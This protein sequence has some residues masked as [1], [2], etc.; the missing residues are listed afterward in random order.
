[1]GRR[2]TPV[3]PATGPVQRFAYELRKL[4]QEAGGLTYREMARRAHYSVTSL[5]QAAAGEQL[6]S[7][8][9]TLAYV[10][11]CGGDPEEWDRRWHEASEESATTREDDDTDA[12]YPGLSRYEPT[13]HDRFFGRDDLVE[14][15]RALTA[16]HRFTAVFGPSGSGKSSLLRAGLIPDLQK[17][18]IAALRI[19]TPG[20]HPLRT[21][22]KALEPQNDGGPGDRGDTGDTVLVVDQ[23][24]EV[25]TLC[26]DQT[27]RTEFIDRLLAART[28][29]GSGLRVVVAVRAD[30]YGHCAEHRALAD[31]LSEASLLVGPMTRAELREA[32]IRPAQSAG[33]IVER[34]LTAHLVEEVDGEPGGLPLL[35]HAL[36]ET[37]RR[38]RGRALTMAAYEAAGGVRG[39]IAKTA[40]DVYA[41]LSPEQAALARQL[42]LRLITPG[43]GS[44]DTRR[45]V[46]RTELGFAPADEVALVLERLTRARLLTLDDNTV[47]LAHE[48]LI[49]S[50]PR[51]H[52]WIGETREHLRTHRRLTEAA[53]AWDDLGR[54]P[55]AL[56]RGTRLATADE[57]LTDQPLAPLEEAFL[58]AS[59]TTHTTELRRRR[60]LFTTLATLLV[61]ALIAGVTAWQQSRTSDRRHREAEARRIATVADSMRFADPVKAM[62]LSVAAWR[63]A[64]T[65]ETRSALLGGMTQHELDT[66]AVPDAD[67]GRRSHQDTPQTALDVTA[68]GRTLVSVSR[69]R[70]RTWD[71]RT[72][73]RTHDHPGP[74]KLMADGSEVVIS[75]DGRLLAL[76]NQGGTRL[77]DVHTG[78]E[79]GRLGSRN[80]SIAAFGPGGRTL[81]VQ[82]D[83][84]EA[85]VAQVWDVRTLRRLIQVGNDF[86]EALRDP[87]TD[88]DG[89]WLVTC[90]D[91]W[92]LQVWDIA[93]QRRVTPPWASR[94][95][96]GSCD[97]EG[98]YGFS[99]DGRQFLVVTDTGVQRW[100]LRSNR[101]LPTVE[102]PGASL[103][104][105]RLSADGR[106]MVAHAGNEIQLWRL[107]VS[108]LSGPV[109]HHALVSEQPGDVELDLAAGAVRYLTPG[110]T[111]VRSLS[112]GRA[113]SRWH[114]QPYDGVLLA[115]DGRTLAVLSPN[116]KTAF[117]LRDTRSGRVISRPP[118]NPCILAGTEAEPVTDCSPPMAF[119]ADGRYFAY[120]QTGANTEPGLSTRQ[121]VMVWD[122]R[123][124]REHAAVDIRTTDIDGVGSLSLTPDG[125]TLLVA[126]H[127]PLIAKSGPGSP[128]VE[129]WDLRRDKKSKGAERARRTRSLPLPGFTGAI[130]ALHPDSRKL[131]SANGTI[132][133]LHS[134]RTTKR[135]LGDDD[136]LALAFSPDGAYLAVADNGGRVT[137]W[138]G[139]LRRRVG[140]LSG[141]YA[142][143]GRENPG[144]VQ[145]LAFSLDGRNLAVAD[146]SGTVQLWDVPSNQRL[147]SALPTPGDGVSSLAFSENGTTLHVTSPHVP[148]QKYDLAPE[149]L[150]H[151]VCTRVGS[152]LSP[153]DW[154]TYLPDLPYERTC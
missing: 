3:D 70:I 40:E 93:E 117:Q 95:R 26:R 64:H 56:Y 101:E 21:H 120:L 36:R 28:D 136:A 142:D 118:G 29:P 46:D 104:D 31:A 97:D 152:G 32:V 60:G 140:I 115:E 151:Q 72:H 47:D 143:T 148:L 33:L 50:W 114:R 57:H 11:A 91:R 139:D 103:Y 24:E 18:G 13:D 89:R 27:E 45:P 153:A 145:A 105:Y 122:V 37:W 58:T 131:V 76:L 7:L 62:Q 116:G 121:R 129:V 8:A 110:G 137:L 43:E 63:L 2:E 12:P 69:D 4:R 150:V 134:G 65:T 71:L 82:I 41:T 112:L 84:G 154:K 15:L 16:S 68:D 92:P 106:F 135:V 133:D 138:D 94:M 54:D 146:D 102:L 48:A 49:T 126:R 79:L 19:L 124:R 87:V 83:D 130:T 38:R 144:S 149:S 44:Q 88:P 113:T 78:R 73:R 5:S 111:A 125:R 17:T 51:L 14:A 53:R 123:A 30:F 66:F 100:D 1:M 147:G 6:P 35:S 9:V 107:S 141:T 20:E 90:R 10:K 119:S 109:F 96:K 39:A 80:A 59:R 34:D 128:V 25:F 52:S 81:I 23:F 98:S 77:W 85:P 132:A 86:S 22:E 99:P 127:G 42:L 74:G 75:P 67:V 55:G 61:L 108:E